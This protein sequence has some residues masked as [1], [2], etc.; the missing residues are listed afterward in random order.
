[1]P[2]NRGSR[3]GVETAL[4]DVSS[5]SS[6]LDRVQRLTGTNKITMARKIGFAVGLELASIKGAG[7]YADIH[8]ELSSLFRRLNLG[9][10]IL[11]EW[12]PVVFVTR[13]DSK[14]ESLEAAFG[15]GVLEGV[16]HARLEEPVFVKHSFP[17]AN[18][19]SSLRFGLGRKSR[20]V[21]RRYDA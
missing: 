4:R 2:S 18:P 15:E 3:Y 17:R 14:A 11:H 10:V 12:A 5:L 1:M 7:K 20:S 6:T 19:Q 8:S 21:K 9:K 13:P 16:V